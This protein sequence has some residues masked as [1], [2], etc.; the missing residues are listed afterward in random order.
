MML[1]KASE[2][3]VDCSKI[4]AYRY[5][6]ETDPEDHQPLARSL[7]EDRGGEANMEKSQRTGKFSDGHN[8]QLAVLMAGKRNRS[9]DGPGQNLRLNS[10]SHTNPNS[11]IPNSTLEILP[12]AKAYEWITL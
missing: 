6:P 11:F 3:Q 5:L 1:C 2:T 12:S 10:C 4:S 8:V 9:G 7:L